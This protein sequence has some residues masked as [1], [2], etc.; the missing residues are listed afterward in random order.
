MYMTIHAADQRPARRRIPAPR[1]IRSGLGLPWWER[2]GV[3]DNHTVA[4]ANQTGTSGQ[5]GQASEK[6]GQVGGRPTQPGGG[7]P[8]TDESAAC[9]C[10]WGEPGRVEQVEGIW[11]V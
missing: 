1:Q 4:S 11:C 6:A 7:A 3:S 8:E 2:L 9:R 10:G 5:P